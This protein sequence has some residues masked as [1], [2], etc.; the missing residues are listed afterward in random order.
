[1]SENN[2]LGIFRRRVDYFKKRAGDRPILYYPQTCARSQYPDSFTP[3]GLYMYGSVVD[4]VVPNWDTSE[5]KPLHWDKPKMYYTTGDSFYK[6]FYKNNTVLLDRTL[7][8]PY[9]QNPVRHG[10]TK[11]VTG[12]RKPS[13]KDKVIWLSEE[14]YQNDY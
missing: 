2:N 11:T 13:V 4:D 5:G 14:K 10:Y 12:Y 6:E 3:S 9:S 1:M 7:Q 8:I